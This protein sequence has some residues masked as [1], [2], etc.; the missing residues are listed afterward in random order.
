MVSQVMN[1]S[2][3]EQQL[4]SCQPGQSPGRAGNYMKPAIK[5]KK[6]TIEMLELHVHV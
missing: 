1:V 3:T 5:R 6:K 2:M 4:Q